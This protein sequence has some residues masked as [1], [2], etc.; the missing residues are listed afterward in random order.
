MH[1]VIICFFAVLFA[2]MHMVYLNINVTVHK[3]NLS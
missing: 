1:L 2:Q 3:K